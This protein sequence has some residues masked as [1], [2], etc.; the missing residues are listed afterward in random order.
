MKKYLKYSGTAF[1]LALMLVLLTACGGQNDYEEE[2]TAQATEESIDEQ[3]DNI[4]DAESSNADSETTDAK[5]D[6]ESNNDTDDNG[7]KTD[8]E[9]EMPKIPI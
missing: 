3:M 8:D 6:A 2:N 1:A 9:I 4:A 7:K 5:T